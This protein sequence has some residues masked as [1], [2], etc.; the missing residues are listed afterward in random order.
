MLFSPNSFFVGFGWPFFIYNL[1][2]SW[3]P[4]FILVPRLFPINF[5]F[6]SGRADCTSSWSLRERERERERER[7]RV[8][9]H[10]GNTIFFCLGIFGLRSAVLYNY[11]IGH[12]TFFFFFFF[13]FF[14]LELS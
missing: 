13:F 1:V 3:D 2:V 7:V 11:I 5:D 12:F 14:F 6:E 8:P 10:F 9:G 4:V